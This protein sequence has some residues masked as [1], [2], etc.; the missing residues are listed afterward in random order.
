MKY[1]FAL[2]FALL[3]TGADAQTVNSSVPSLAG[4]WTAYTPVL[5]CG[6]GTLT[7]SS[8][9]GRFKTVD[10]TTFVQFAATLT[11]IGTCSGSIS[12]SVP[13]AAVTNSILFGRESASTGAAMLGII[14]PGASV[15]GVTKYD[16]TPIITAGF[17]Y[18]FSGSYENQ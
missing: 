12:V 10:K 5:A 9:T 2:F 11:T 14:A 1:L 17:V 3:I 4:A 8:T 13:A 16:G 15:V 18:I 7:T 6:T